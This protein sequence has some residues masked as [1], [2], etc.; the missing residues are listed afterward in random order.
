ME[1]LPIL[2][3]RAQHMPHGRSEAAAPVTLSASPPQSSA[4]HVAAAVSIGDP[5]H[6][7]SDGSADRVP[8]TSSG[9]VTPQ[10]ATP[11]APA[12]SP[13]AES[14]EPHPFLQQRRL[15]SILLD[16]WEFRKLAAEGSVLA[17]AMLSYDVDDDGLEEVI[18]GTTEGL[19][20]V[21]KPDC[22]EP[23]F[24]RTLA[25]T[26]SVV[27]YTP[28][29]SRLV[30][31][32][33]EGQCEV[34]DHFL[35]L[36][37]QQR[38]CSESVNMNA[39][40][41]TEGVDGGAASVCGQLY[42][43][44]DSANSQPRTSSSHYGGGRSASS[45]RG[46]ATTTPHSAGTPWSTESCSPTHVFHVPS[47]CLCADLSPDRDADLV[48]LGS[49][50]RRFYVYSIINGSCLLSLF[51]HDPITSVK[52]FAIPTSAA[53][54]HPVTSSLP[55][56]VYDQRALTRAGR[57]GSTSG[58]RR[59]LSS[60]SAG[61]GGAGALDDSPREAETPP[62]RMG[63]ASASPHIPLVFIST[64]THLILLP[65][66][67]T[68]I[69]Q[70]RKLQ[71]KSAH[72][73]LTVQLR[74]DDPAATLPQSLRHPLRHEH[75][76]R[77]SSIDSGETAKAGTALTR[78]ATARRG[79]DGD[80]PREGEAAL[81]PQ[82]TRAPLASSPGLRSPPTVPADTSRGDPLGFDA[83]RSQDSSHPRRLCG[84]ATESR[85]DCTDVRTEGGCLTSDDSVPVATA[86]AAVAAGAGTGSS[87]SSSQ[88]RRQAR[89]RAIQ[90]AEM[91][92]PVLV[93]PLWVL[94]IRSHAL[95]VPLLQ[96]MPI[97]D[98]NIGGDF[99]S[100]APAA[101]TAGALRPFSAPEG[102]AQ[103]AAA[104][105]ATGVS[106]ALHGGFIASHNTC[107]SVLARS[108]T[109]AP[110][111]LAGTVAFPP[112]DGL[113][114]VIGY[115]G[116]GA[117]KAE[118]SN[119]SQTLSA[120]AAAVAQN[121]RQPSLRQLSN[122][123]SSR[124]RQG[125]PN[126]SSDDD[127]RVVGLQ[128]SSDDDD[129]ETGLLSSDAALGFGGSAAPG[130]NAAGMADREQKEDDNGDGD[131][132]T[133]G[134][135]GFGLDKSGTSTSTTYNSGSDTHDRSSSGEVYDTVAASGQRLLANSSTRHSQHH[136]QGTG[137]MGP[138]LLAP[139]MPH[140]RAQ[141]VPTMLLS[142]SRMAHSANMGRGNRG[143]G[144]L[145]SAVTATTAAAH[146]SL[147]DFTKLYSERH[148]RQHHRSVAV[149]EDER[150]DR[151][152]SR[153]RRSR[154]IAHREH[155]AL[156]HHPARGRSPLFTAAASAPAGTEVRLPTSVDVSVGVSQVAVALSCEDGLALELRFS[157]VR[158]SS[159]SRCERRLPQGTVRLYDMRGRRLSRASASAGCGS[160][161]KVSPGAKVVGGAVSPARPASSP[162]SPGGT[163]SFR[164]RGSHG[165]ELPRQR[166]KGA[167]Q[168]TYNIYLPT[169][170]V[171]QAGAAAA[172]PSL[173]HL[174]GVPL[175]S[176]RQRQRSRNSRRG[177]G[178]VGGAL[179]TT[180]VM[181]TP[182]T[183]NAISVMGSPLAAD[184][185]GCSASAAA[186]RRQGSMS[187]EA[188]MLEGDGATGRNS[189]VAL[190]QR[191]GED[192][193]V[194]RAQCLWAARLSD[195][196]LVQRARVFC[197]RDSHSQNT[198]CSV[199]VAANGTCFA[200]DGDTM[201]VVKCCVKE[202]CS[203]F[204]VMVGPFSTAPMLST[205]PSMVTLR[206]SSADASAF[207]Q[208]GALNALS[209][210]SSASTVTLHLLRGAVGR[211]VSCVCVSI[212]ELCV[213]SVGE[214]NQLC[215]H[216]DSACGALAAP[217]TKEPISLL[218]R[219]LP[220]N[221][222]AGVANGT[223]ALTAQPIEDMDGTAASLLA[224]MDPEEQA[225]LSQLAMRLR[226]HEQRASAPSHHDSD[227]GATSGG[228][229]AVEADEEVLARLKRMLL[230]DYS[231]HEWEKLQSIEHT[232][233]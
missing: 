223:S 9:D 155:Y 94:R 142:H 171:R 182:A 84:T 233:V 73:P 104:G 99:A 145:L 70:W 230:Y 141:S 164:S 143:G 186:D 63:K 33:L 159:L 71:P 175:A 42:Q 105:T 221:S 107:D 48:F 148:T 28:I 231:E 208:D 106:S 19:L 97:P 139:S 29:H 218:S 169:P 194:L 45:A 170:A 49:Y 32:T 6:R 216:R 128:C 16:S 134:D 154:R 5:R 108:D 100:A 152:A 69:Q 126:N 127:G 115:G 64:P 77:L 165:S 109:L 187:G 46:G 40:L 120:T 203:S 132:G 140:T 227:T 34:T 31:V 7:Q 39:T 122:T 213:Y 24:M 89:R 201:S 215:R 101:A 212:D 151:R 199:F 178:D 206:D 130:M 74:R 192:T 81:P 50:D 181:S 26:I 183:V 91:G 44:S 82:M 41:P 23:L 184:N 27:L 135:E 225:L 66:G 85:R 188:T 149:R 72:L 179:P 13:A 177:C 59:T 191:Y 103:E 17:N 174:S 61:T 129:E 173:S 118:A 98:D 86:T 22:R 56:C 88:L 220:D 219:C 54:V 62:D 12:A 8:V 153:D 57:G 102:T 150:G 160:S 20:C 43:G 78:S 10:S 204:T 211:T 138:A 198:F 36:T 87:L 228:E 38:A 131:I 116:G 209:P 162:G 147:E 60:S 197:V 163:R 217:G 210:A 200:V 4:A 226:Q 195:S 110:P 47:N 11:Y 146:L 112:E 92:R 113:R 121:N 3:T 67:L 90:A 15:P 51:V 37:Q 75:T 167:S 176:M 207:A 232:L 125:S 133:V 79:S 83:V 114:R 123:R 14:P 172:L 111:S 214:A 30:L 137:T 53:D 68:D 136:H 2:P 117:E 144:G 229:Q 185:T 25:A 1:Q 93:K 205:R 193:V 189:H 18:V 76:R 80:H 119:P 55:I 124:T 224:S 202:D 35:R 168:V 58:S 156:Q 95:D 180:E 21:V 65:G 158:L 96:T 157:V 196:P 166:R 190:A 161:K 52:A 222:Y